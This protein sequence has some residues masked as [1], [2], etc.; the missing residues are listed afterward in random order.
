MLLPHQGSSIS[1]LTPQPANQHLKTTTRAAALKSTSE[2]ATP[3]GKEGLLSPSGHISAFLC[4]V[5]HRITG[6]FPQ[7]SLPFSSTG[8]KPSPEPHTQW[9]LAF[10]PPLAED[11]FLR[12]PG[13]YPDP[14]LI[15]LLTSWPEEPLSAAEAPSL[16][17]SIREQGSLPTRTF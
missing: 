12:A 4:I 14:L 7:S 13:A 6:V 17:S 10:P 8:P 11:E 9:W 3:H 15:Y 16:N 5:N 1:N 2:G